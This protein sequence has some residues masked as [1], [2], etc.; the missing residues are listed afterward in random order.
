MLNGG[1]ISWS[2]RK[3]KVVAISSFES[4]WYSASICGCEVKAMR[5]LLEEMGYPQSAPTT[6][7]ED[8]AACIYSSEA[9][10]PMNPCSKHINIRVFKLKEF[11]QEGTLKLVKVA[12]ERQMADNLTKPLHKIGVDMARAVMSGEE[13]V[14]QARARAASSSRTLFGFAY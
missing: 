1:A 11:V 5:R 6:L 7:F 10:R 14:R 9:D 3:I 4:E 12:T 13:A 8:N 2:S